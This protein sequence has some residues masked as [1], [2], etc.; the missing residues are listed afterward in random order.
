[1]EKVRS[2]MQNQRSC[3]ICLDK[4]RASKL[5]LE[6]NIKKELISDLSF[7]SRKPPEFMSHRLMRCLSCG[8]VYAPTPPSVEDLSNAYHQASYDSSEEAKD[9]AQSYLKSTL[10]V[11]KRISGLNLALE[12]GTGSG[13]FLDLLYDEGFKNLI[14]IEPSMAAIN[15]ASPKAR[16]WIR[17]EIF[18][19][20]NFEPESFDLICCF[21]TLEHVQDPMEI[22][23][24]A[25]K[26]L[27]KGG[28]FVTVTHDYE[29][30]LNRLLG[31]RSPII[32]IEHMQLFS[33][34]SIKQ[35]FLNGGF[36]SIQSDS[37]QNR[38][39][40]SY[41]LRLLPLPNGIKDRVNKFLA[42]LGLSG[43]KLAANVGN[44]FT[45]GLK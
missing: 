22:T 11:L 13:I 20:K 36:H 23:L 26:L 32:D 9:A 3:P 29:G 40:V 19:E 31:K 33:K 8:L 25:Y 38:Y 43:I 42:L 39:A 17:H 1:M 24:A 30:L 41:W 34:Q 18:E 44:I 15:S 35:L 37:F 28:A 21:M 14:G 7:A 4:Y 2:N 6:E 10:P 12:I 27:R 5:F 16:Q 45:V